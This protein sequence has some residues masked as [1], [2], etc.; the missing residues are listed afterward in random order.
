MQCECLL[1][2]AWAVVG[3]G[4]CYGNSVVVYKENKQRKRTE[5]DNTHLYPKGATFCARLNKGIG[6]ALFNQQIF[7]ISYGPETVLGAGV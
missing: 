6:W 2:L 7:I 4:V 3:V 1:S 5:N